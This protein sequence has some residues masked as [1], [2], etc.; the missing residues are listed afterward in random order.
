MNKVL[1]HLIMIYLFCLTMG[2]LF[3]LYLVVEAI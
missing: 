1:F 3:G 2:T